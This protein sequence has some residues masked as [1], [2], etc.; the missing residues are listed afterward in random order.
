VHPAVAR[1][2][3]AGLMRV[4]GVR[5]P[6]PSSRIIACDFFEP[7]TPANVHTTYA[8]TDA[9]RALLGLSPLAPE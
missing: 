8:A 6:P 7:V 2:T 5:A 4:L 9:A 1:T 3:I